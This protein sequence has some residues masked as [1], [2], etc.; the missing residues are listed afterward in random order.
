MFIN[1]NGI[2]IT[3]NFQKTTMEQRLAIIGHRNCTQVEKDLAYHLGYK[4]VRKGYWVTSGLALGIDTSGLS[5]AIQACIDGYS[6]GVI[7][8]APTIYPKVYPTTNKYLYDLVKEHG[9]LLYPYGD[10]LPTHTLY[11]SRA[12]NKGDYI[13]ILPLLTDRS[14]L[15]GEMCNQVHI[16]CDERVI[17]GGSRYALQKAMDLGREVYQWYSN[18]EYHSTIQLQRKVNTNTTIYNIDNILGL[19]NC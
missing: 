5:G 15:D 9:Y 8:I 17:T 16:I 18:G 6:G 11:T 1:E 12:K 13:D 4:M 7:G 10:T 19:I 3:G 2:I 14:I